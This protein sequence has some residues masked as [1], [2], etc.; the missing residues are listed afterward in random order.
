MIHLA[1]IAFKNYKILE[2]S[3]RI[4]SY[5][6]E[7]SL[8]QEKIKL[9]R[10]LK[11]KLEFEFE[12]KKILQLTFETMPELFLQFYWFDYADFNWNFFLISFL[13]GLISCLIAADYMHYIFEI[14]D[15]NT[16]KIFF[17]CLRSVSNFFFMSC[18]YLTLVTL[19]LD[20]EWFLAYTISF[21]S[22]FSQPFHLLFIFSFDNKKFFFVFFNFEF[23]TFFLL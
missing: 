23:K 22:I 15:I 7:I 12:F 19:S 2:F 4:E 18:R 21:C 17:V 10:Q 3:K 14:N 8:E 6:E 20:S 9:I 11:L 5:Q 1:E 13:R 16:N